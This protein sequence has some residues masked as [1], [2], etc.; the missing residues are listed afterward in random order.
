MSIVVLLDGVRRYRNTSIYSQS[1]PPSDAQDAVSVA[2]VALLGELVPVTILLSVG[3]G[4]DRFNGVSDAASLRA[5]AELTKV[6][7]PPTERFFQRGL[8]RGGWALDPASCALVH[9]RTRQRVR[10]AG[11]LARSR[12]RA[13]RRASRRTRPASSTCMRGSRSGR[14]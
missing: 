4:A 6:A 2:A 13:T 12:S 8:R 1:P 7:A 9:F 5:V 11:S 10:P 14:S 3:F